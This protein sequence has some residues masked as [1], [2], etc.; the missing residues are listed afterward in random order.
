MRLGDFV[1]EQSVESLQWS[2]EKSQMINF[3]F[4]S[5]LICSSIIT[6]RRRRV[7]IGSLRRK[8]IR[9]TYNFVIPFANCSEVDQ[10]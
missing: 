5:C 3:K 8:N 10:T 9:R 6:R 2:N 4:E 7:A 1:D